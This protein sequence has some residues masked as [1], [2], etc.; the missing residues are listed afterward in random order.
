VAKDDRGKFYDLKLPLADAKGRAIGLT[1]MEIPFGAARDENDALA[2]AAVVRDEMQKRISS[3]AELFEASTAP[4]AESQTIP[5]D[6]VIKGSFD[7]FG[8]DVKHNRL[9]A[10]PEYYHAVLVFDLVNAS[11]SPRSRTWADRT[12][13]FIV[14]T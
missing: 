11:R 12:R 13:S 4:L 8:V 6:P 14:T 7:H 1:V 2:K 9:F 5:L 10:T 3:A